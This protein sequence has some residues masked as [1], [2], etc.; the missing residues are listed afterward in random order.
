[1]TR[2]DGRAADQ[3][4][5]VEIIRRYTKFAPGSALIAVGDTRVLCTASVDERPPRFL[6]D[7]NMDARGWVTAEYS[8]L[9]GST[10]ERTQREA[11]RGRPS[12]RTQEIQRLIGRALRAVTDLTAIGE[13][14]VWIDCDV[15]QAD[16]GTRTASITG[17]CIALMDACTKLRDDGRLGSVFPVK[18]FVAATSV[19][20]VQ[21]APLLDLC[22]S[23]DSAADVDA[24]VVMTGSGEFVEIQGTAEN[25]TFSRAQSDLLL[26]LA[27]GGIHDIVELQKRLILEDSGAVRSGHEEPTQV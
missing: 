13:R 1:M 20:I 3:M 6:Q 10:P 11:S 2:A 23:E 14:T 26:D 24:N 18:D 8:M 25:V 22:Y 21:G 17:A 27:A 5:P 19:G 7:Q 16:G 15:L 12:G 4:R 9:P